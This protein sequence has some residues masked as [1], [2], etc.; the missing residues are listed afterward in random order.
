MKSLF[1]LPDFISIRLLLVGFGLASF[2]GSLFGQLIFGW[3]P[4][5][6][7]LI[8][9]FL[10]LCALLFS[11]LALF[12]RRV[13]VLSGVFFLLMGVVAVRQILLPW[14]PFEASC[15]FSLSP[16]QGLAALYS[17]QSDCAE[18]TPVFLLLPLTYWSL[19]LALFGTLFSVLRLREKS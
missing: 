3:L 1:R 9:R 14:F 8:Q 15:A 13:A 2:G 18:P 11:L 12:Y 5:E 7:C 10:G 19:I 17:P 4:C 16:P 6:L